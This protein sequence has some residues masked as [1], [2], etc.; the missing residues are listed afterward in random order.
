MAKAKADLLVIGV[1][2]HA[3]AVDPETG[4]ELWRTRLR[5]TTFVTVCR[6]G[7]RVF[8]GAGGEPLCLD[9]GSGNILR[10]DRPKGLGLGFAAFF[11][12]RC[13]SRARAP[14]SAPS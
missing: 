12:C 5:T 14:V 3:V 7:A 2:G 11:E 1:G 13:A 8:A 6:D 9:A 10:R 4:T